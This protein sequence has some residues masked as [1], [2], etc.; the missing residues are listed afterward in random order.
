MI[1]NIIQEDFTPKWAANNI[2]DP[3]HQLAVLRKIIP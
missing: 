1:T 3:A 2:S